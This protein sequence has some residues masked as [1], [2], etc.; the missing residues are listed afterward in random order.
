[1][2]C[3]IFVVTKK[4]VGGESATAMEVFKQRMA[5]EFWGIYEKSQHRQEV[6]PGDHIVFYVGTPDKVF[7]GTAVAASSLLKLSA[8]EKKDYGHGSQIYTMV[9]GVKLASIQIRQRPLQAGS[10]VHKLSFVGNQP[11]WGTYFQRSI[12]PITEDDYNLLVARPHRSP[13]WT[14]DELILAL[15]LYFRVNPRS[16][17][18]R[19]PEIIELS[20]L[21]NSLPI[22]SEA[23]RGVV[24]RNPQGVYMK[25]CNFWHLDPDNPGEG[26]KDGSHLGEDVWN[27]FKD[28]RNRLNATANQI[29]SNYQYIEPTMIEGGED[30]TFQEGRVVTMLHKRF[31]RNGSAPKQKKKQVMEKT[32]KLACEVCGFDFKERYGEIGD[33][34]AEC[35]HV[36]PVSELNGTQKTRLKDLA[37]VCP[38]CHRM[39]HR[40]RPPKTVVELMAVVS[41]VSP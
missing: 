4:N 19:N 24:F 29:R 6:N 38:N 20:L 40:S 14:R 25:L 33:G 8:K 26:L 35:H 41:S 36:V 12:I 39:L 16:T 37:I 34:F 1:M 11:A 5:D 13:A 28:D 21:L 23:L 31:E 3:W 10:V 27:E 17:S 22:H 7:A 15:D 32:G 18:H 30:E 9:Q 2:N